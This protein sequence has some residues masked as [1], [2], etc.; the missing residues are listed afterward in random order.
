MKKIKVHKRHIIGSIENASLLRKFTI[1]F[2]IMSFLP[3]VVLYYFYIQL[4]DHGHI[5]ISEQN[6]NLTLTFLVLGVIL[7][8]FTMRAALI[9][10]IKLIVSNAQAMEE[11]LSPAEIEELSKEKNELNVL[12]E[13]FKIITKKMED[14]MRNLE[15]AKRTLHSVL[16][17]VGQGMSTMDN[18]DSFLEL[19]IETVTEAVNGK[20]GTI[21]LTEKGGHDLL[22]KVTFGHKLA[23]TE[24]VR[25]S[26]E[27]GTAIHTVM[28]TR[29]P[30]ILAR[31]GND[32]IEGEESTP[33]F[34]APMI[35]APMIANDRVLGVICVSGHKDEGRFEEDETGLLF[36]LATQTAIAV[37]NAELN[38]DIEKTYFE[39]ITALAMAIDAKDKFSRGHLNRV[40]D[41]CTKMGKKLGLEEEDI[42]TLRAAARLHDIGKIGIPDEVLQKEG[43]L[44]EEERQLMIRHTEI[45]ESIIKP[46]RSLQHLC[47]PI[48][49]HHEKLD[50]TGYPDGLKG[51]EISP[52]V[53]I[54]SIAD[55]FDALTT[56]RPYRKKYSKDAAIKMMR[57]MK[58]EIDQDLVE[59]FIEILEEE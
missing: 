14:N 16:T 47:D 59:A 3:T 10:L 32:I 54:L 50:G 52:L 34:N 35:V 13:A 4:R 20:V 25:I 23:P 6:L 17:K 48:R 55:I 57:E 11:S 51:N 28:T 49:H 19:I 29:K 37:E 44:T 31:A 41:L 45:G 1:L 26:I 5:T 38:K 53:R 56:D 24:E 36:N 2:L 15:L 12:A 27:K 9:Q 33:L 40:S 8:Y 18:I 43:K 30:V 46:I 7:G 58:T 39:T 22:V 42:R 21:L